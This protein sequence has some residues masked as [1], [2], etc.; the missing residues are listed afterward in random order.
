ME[1]KLKK[2]YLTIEEI[3]NIVNQ[4]A[5]KHTS[6]E[7]ELIKTVLVAK[8]CLDYDFGDKDDVTVYNELAEKDFIDE[9]YY[10]I[11]NVY[12]L[13]NCISEENSIEQTFREFLEGLNKSIEKGM[14]KIPKNFD[15]KE[16]IKKVEEVVGR[17]ENNK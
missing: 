2:N 14:K 8:Y 4:C 6:Y 5:E 3:G 16:F 13:E 10:Y 15:T 9:C 12:V 11:T 17:K 7:C 1:L